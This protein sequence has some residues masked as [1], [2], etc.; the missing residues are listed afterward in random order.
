MNIIVNAIPLTGLLTGI[1]RYVRC[2]Y[3][4]LQLLQDV[5]VSYFNGSSCE[6]EMPS[7]AEPVSWAKATEQVWRLPDL[8]VTGMSVLQWLNFERH[9]RAACRR[10]HFNVYH[11]TAFIPAAIK[12]IPV[13]Y[14]LYDISL[15]KYRSEHPRERV[16]FFDLL[17][18]RR[19]PYAVHIIT[20]SDF[21]RKEL[22]DTLGINE[23][24]ITAIPLAP[25]PFFYPRQQAEIDN[26]IDMHGWPREYILFVG[27]LEPRKNIS[28]LIKALS[29]TKSDI[30][31]ILAGWKGWG[32][33][34]WL[35][36]VVALGLEKRVYSADYLDEETL[37]CLY[38][39]ARALVYPSLY[40]GFGL[41]VL[42][43]MACGCP[44]IC[45][46]VASMPEVAGKAALLVDPRDVDDMTATIDYLVGDEEARQR[47]IV[48]GFARA[49]DFT[50]QQ[51]AEQ[52]REVFRKVIEAAE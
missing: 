21:M 12:D 10:N 44:V 32:D 25:D 43:A 30:P 40:E 37:A 46:N 18:K 50:W 7:Q 19:L 23:D 29:R 35:H 8:Y 22:I 42:E 41:P 15:I 36:D 27:T 51:T 34:I 26:V 13:V 28:L 20:I 52:T 24:L 2:L 49:A 6:S 47:F 31:L 33:K 38:S 5:L 1:S 4:R 11:E 45:S 16:W 14:T 39:G 17:F 9:L 3:S 48:K